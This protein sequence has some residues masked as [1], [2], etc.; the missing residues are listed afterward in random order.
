MTAITARLRC[1]CNPARDRVF[2]VFDLAGTL[3]VA[4]TSSKANDA[5]KQNKFAFDTSYAST[6]TMLDK[7]DGGDLGKGG[8]IVKFA[9]DCG[10]IDIEF[11]RRGTGSLTTQAAR[12]S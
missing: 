3:S 5:I 12:A 11:G 7:Y 2:K 10:E 4:K 8:A 1:G 6:T 9:E